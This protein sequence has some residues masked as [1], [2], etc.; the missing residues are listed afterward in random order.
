MGVDFA[1]G[2]GIAKPQPLSENIAIT[3]MESVAKALAGT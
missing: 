3:P 1:Q 2:Y